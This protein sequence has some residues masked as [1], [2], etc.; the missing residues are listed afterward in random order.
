MASQGPILTAKTFVKKSYAELKKT[1][2]PSREETIK[3]TWAVIV[4]SAILAVVL[5]GLDYL[6]TYLASSFLL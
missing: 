1:N 4:L 2:W 6:F 5:G 3:Y